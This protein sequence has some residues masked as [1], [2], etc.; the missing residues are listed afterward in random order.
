M[1]S[2]MNKGSAVSTRQRTILTKFCGIDD[3]QDDD[4]V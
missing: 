3:A 1:S 2:V 4:M